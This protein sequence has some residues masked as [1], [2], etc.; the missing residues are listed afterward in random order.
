[1]YSP[2]PP[3]AALKACS[4]GKANAG[5]CSIK[6][7]NDKLQ[8]FVPASLKVTLRWTSPAGT[9]ITKTNQKAS[10]WKE[11]LSW[12]WDGTNFQ[13]MPTWCNRPTSGWEPMN[14]SDNS[15]L[16][17]KLLSATQKTCSKAVCPQNHCCAACYRL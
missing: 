4:D 8:V 16:P 7:C 11:W 6:V 12:N 3:A 14:G 1:M 17:G 2:H 13:R 9:I 5:K 10:S 15:N